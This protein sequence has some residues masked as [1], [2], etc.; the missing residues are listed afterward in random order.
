MA[1]KHILQVL[2]SKRAGNFAVLCLGLLC[3]YLFLWREM[4]FF[5]VPSA[6][7]EPT[8][9]PGDYL[10]TLNKTEYKRGDI[11]VFR[12]MATSENLVKR[13]AGLPGDTLSV[14]AGALF[15]NGDYAS[16]PYIKEPM[17]YTIE[18]PVKVPEGKIFVLGDNRNESG[19]SSTNL[20]TFPLDS[21]VGKV[22]YLYFPY[23]RMGPVA[24]YP[25]LN[26][27]GE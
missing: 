16:E 17:T 21:I 13:I 4:R 9:Y 20:E 23:A 22:R 18:K 24:S 14:G 8:L 1:M 7:M 5:T 19:D 3:V 27:K 15:I 2:R 10:V 6:S 25:L 11:V 26:S 12:D